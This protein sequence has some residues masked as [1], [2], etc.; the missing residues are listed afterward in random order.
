M[1]SQQNYSQLSDKELIVYSQSRDSRAFREL[2]RRYEG[3]IGSLLGYYAADWKDLA[4]LKQELLIRVWRGISGL[5]DPVA[6]KAWVGQIVSNLFYDELAKRARQIP[7]IQL[8]VPDEQQHDIPHEIQDHSAGPEELYQYRQLRI[9]ILRA[10]AKLPNQY[11]TAIVLHE[12][13][14]LS[15]VEIAA[16]TRSSLGTVKSRISRARAMLQKSLASCLNRT[17]T[18]A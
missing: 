9:L 6:F 13:N 15:Y 5:R 18:A 3:Y 17:A 11:R 10:I 8:H 1:P 16:V 7:T 14:A 12:I 2:A 4:D